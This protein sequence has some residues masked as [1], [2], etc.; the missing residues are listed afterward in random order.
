MKYLVILVL[1]SSFIACDNSKRKNQIDKNRSEIRHD[2]TGPDQKVNENVHAVKSEPK[3][4][5][6]GEK[7]KMLVSAGILNQ[8]EAE[9]YS[10]I[11]SEFRDLRIDYQKQNIWDGTNQKSI[12]IRNNWIKSKK[13]RFIEIIGEE[14]YKE[15]QNYLKS[16]K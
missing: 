14:K 4:E 6:L 11:E 1:I 3:E 13:A 9:Q 10:E 7:Y 12:E 15:I 5:E 16:L 2:E 8:S